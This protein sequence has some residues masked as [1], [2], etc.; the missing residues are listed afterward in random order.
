MLKT[1]DPT[2]AKQ[3]PLKRTPMDDTEDPESVQ[4]RITRTFGEALTPAQAVD[5]I[6][7]DIRTR[8]DAALGDWSEKLDGSR[9][10]GRCV[11]RSELQD[12]LN[13]LPAEQR[14]ALELAADRVCRFHQAQ[15]V[16]S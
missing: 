14:A 10:S 16:T 5:R 15:P 3:T 1:Y 11:P 4:A 8:G 13:A 6:L 7:R 12:A 9:Y 2:T